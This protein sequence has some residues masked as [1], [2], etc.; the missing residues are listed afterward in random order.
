VGEGGSVD[1]HGSNRPS[2][3]C[4]GNGRGVKQIN[5][6]LDLD[7]R[8]DGGLTLSSFGSLAGPFLFALMSGSGSSDWEI[9]F[10]RKRSKRERR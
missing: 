10:V 8:R 6:G 1:A 9:F 5:V 7:A 3:R 4:Y 2:V